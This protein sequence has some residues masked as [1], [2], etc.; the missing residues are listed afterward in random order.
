MPGST[1]E[2]V[3]VDPQMMVEIDVPQLDAISP[4]PL[5]PW[6]G[7]LELAAKWL[8]GVLRG[9]PKLSSD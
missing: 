7:G 2:S 5:P 1:H 4:R 3:S 8:Q 6:F 9:A